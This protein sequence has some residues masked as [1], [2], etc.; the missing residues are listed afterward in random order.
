VDY[1]WAATGLQSFVI[2]WL[3]P[4]HDHLSVAVSMVS[5]V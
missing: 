2:V 3:I 1:G 4:P 5:L